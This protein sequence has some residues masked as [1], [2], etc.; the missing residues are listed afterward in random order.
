MSG[1]SYPTYNDNEMNDSKQ[2]IL[3][4]ISYPGDNNDKMNR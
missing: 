4:A 3:I 2:I 1:I